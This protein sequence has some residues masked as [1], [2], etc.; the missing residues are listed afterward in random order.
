MAQLRANVLRR[1]LPR[2]LNAENRFLEE[3]SRVF[4]AFQ[5]RKLLKFRVAEFN[6]LLESGTLFAKDQN[7]LG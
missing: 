5:A 6:P 1:R 2:V 3:V 7:S 4:S